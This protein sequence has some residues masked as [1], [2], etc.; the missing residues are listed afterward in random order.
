MPRLERSACMRH[1]SVHRLFLIAGAAAL[2]GLGCAA[3]QTKP[4]DGS[5][6]ARAIQRMSPKDAA[7]AIRFRSGSSFEIHQS[8]LKIQNQYAQGDPRLSQRVVTLNAFTPG[9]EAKLQWTLQQKVETDEYKQALADFRKGATTTESK[10][11]YGLLVTAGSLT[12]LNLWQTHKLMLPLVWPEGEG[13]AL[14]ASGVWVSKSVFEELSRTRVSTVYL[15]FFEPVAAL[16][17]D[18]ADLQKALDLLRGQVDRIAARVDV[19]LMKA[20]GDLAEQKL[21]VNGQEV[22]VQVIRARNWFGEMTV[23]NNPDNPLILSFTLNPPLT[24]EAAE[25]SAGMTLLK[26]MLSFTVTRI[27]L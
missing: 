2:T 27:D 19:D 16:T 8:A 18:N 6:D 25:A 4:S 21:L 1:Y 23:L 15:N 9:T 10:P 13:R 12:A 26:G 20:E 22:S 3:N 5:V 7:R 24:G 17:A 11:T 14:S